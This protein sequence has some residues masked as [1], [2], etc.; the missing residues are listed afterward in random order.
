MVRKGAG[1]DNPWSRCRTSPS[2]LWS[3]PGLPHGRHPRSGTGLRTRPALPRVHGHVRSSRQPRPVQDQD[4]RVPHPG[5]MHLAQMLNKAVQF[6]IADPQVGFYPGRTYV[7]RRRA[8]EA[9]ERPS[10]RAA[11]SPPGG[12]SPSPAPPERRTSRPCMH[13]CGHARRS[14]GRRRRV[15][16]APGTRVGDSHVEEG[17]PPLPVVAAHRRCRAHR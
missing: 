5:K 3:R 6:L 13:L 11:R 16:R 17:V 8:Q 7:T 10:A 1:H 14:R 9:P 2:T 4:H 15:Q 12:T